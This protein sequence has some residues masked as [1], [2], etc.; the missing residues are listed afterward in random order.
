[1]LIIFPMKKTDGS[2]F[3]VDSFVLWHKCT[4]PLGTN[5]EPSGH[6]CRGTSFNI[7]RSDSPK[8]ANFSYFRSSVRV[9][10]YFVIQGCS[11]PH[12]GL[13][14]CSLRPLNPEDI[15]CKF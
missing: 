4:E 10:G 14:G 8:D 2:H 11:G 12:Q 3:D 9:Q 5:E 1:M 15:L 7:N 6:K 13:M